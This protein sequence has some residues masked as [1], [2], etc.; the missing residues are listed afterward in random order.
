[1]AKAKL[2]WGRDYEVING[3]VYDYPCVKKGHRHTVE[4]ITPEM[5]DALSEEAYNEDA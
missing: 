2:K 1:M 5:E 3:F 4:C